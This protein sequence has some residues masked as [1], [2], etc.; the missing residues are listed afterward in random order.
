MSFAEDLLEQAHYLAYRDQ[1]QASLRR[2]VSTAYYALFHLLIDDAVNN[3]AVDH[4]RRVIARTFEHGKMRDVCDAL[5]R[6]IRSGIQKPKEL[7]DVAVAFT[8]LQQHRHTADYDIGENW[9]LRDVENVLELAD[10]AFAAWAAVRSHKEAQDFI[11]D[12][13]MPKRPNR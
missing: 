5:V 4:Q 13:M 11:L 7:N 9:T 2:A 6:A 8:Q 3:W 10:K 12:L 1:G